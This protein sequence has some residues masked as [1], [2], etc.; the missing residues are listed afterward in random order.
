LLI[1]VLLWALSH[2]ISAWIVRGVEMPVRFDITTEQAYSIAFVFL[3]LYFVL[4]SI[5]ATVDN[6]I[7]SFGIV[8]SVTYDSAVQTQALHDFYKSAITFVV[9]LTCVLGAPK[10]ARKLA[11]RGSESP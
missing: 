4:T 8:E 6:S 2:A 1:A 7:R 5:G 10:W 11:R 3:G 9:G